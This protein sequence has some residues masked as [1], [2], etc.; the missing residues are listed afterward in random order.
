MIPK[1]VRPSA[2]LLAAIVLAACGRSA[3]PPTSAPRV[4]HRIV[5]LV[6]STTEILFAIGA[7]DRVVG[8]SAFCD[9]PPEATSRPRVGGFDNPSLE[10]IL[11]LHPDLVTGARGPANRGVVDR[12]GDDGIATWFPP[13]RSLADVRTTIRGLGDRTGRRPGAD[14]LVAR[15]DAHFDAIAAAVASEPRPRVLLV[16]GERP[17]SVAGPGSFADETLRLAGGTNAIG[18]T[19]AYPTIDVERVLALA[20]DV[21]IEAGMG[22]SDDGDGA[23]LRES[24]ARFPTIPA[25]RTG[26]LYFV[27]DERVLRPGPRLADGVAVLARLLHPGV[28]VP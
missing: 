24:W 3:S 25:V 15:V 28:V 2:V 26:R 16:F 19:I 9:Y 27:N 10:A 5:S 7:G 12:L 17:L 1:G 13:D 20:P 14:A 18:G 11:A 23:Q 6:P 22:T 8:I 4:A 21:I